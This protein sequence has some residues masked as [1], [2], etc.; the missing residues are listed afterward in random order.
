MSAPAQ[1]VPISVA[2]D[3]TVTIPAQVC[4]ELGLIPGDE[5]LVPTDHEGQVIGLV[6]LRYARESN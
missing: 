5:L 1:A 3:G 2:A 4:V 6:P